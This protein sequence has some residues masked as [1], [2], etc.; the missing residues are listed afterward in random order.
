MKNEKNHPVDV[1][2]QSTRPVMLQQTVPSSSPQPQVDVFVPSR[3]YP[4]HVSP[5][6]PRMLSLLIPGQPP[7]VFV[8]PLV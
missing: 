1:Q 5:S 4:Y 7:F 3:Q 8:S 6:F 2:S